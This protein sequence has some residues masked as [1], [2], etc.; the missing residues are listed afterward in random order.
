MTVAEAT[1]HLHA[2]LASATPGRLRV[3]VARGRRDAA[4]L[5]RVQARL[6]EEPHVGRVRAA[7]ASGSLVVHYDPRA[8]G[9]DDVVAMLLDLGVVVTGVLGGGYPGPLP[10]AGKST[11]ASGLVAALE[12]M[13]RR[14]SQATGRTID[15]K[16]LVP[17]S[18]GAIGL[19][20]LMRNGLMLSEVPAFVLLWYAFDS[21][22]KLHTVHAA[23]PPAEP[24][25]AQPPRDEPPSAP[26]ATPRGRAAPEQPAT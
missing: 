10:E 17:A 20:Q 1:G 8:L 14:L 15:L 21:F 9:T 24:E 22:Y 4:A 7:P 11:T 2:Q 3:Q 5:R 12:D 16:L 23:L 19:V 25:P 6:E 18:L 13:D 26:D